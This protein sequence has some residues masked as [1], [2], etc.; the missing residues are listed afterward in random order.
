MQRR[1]IRTEDIISGSCAFSQPFPP[2]FPPPAPGTATLRTCRARTP[3]DTPPSP[4]RFLAT[5][6]ISFAIVFFVVREHDVVTSASRTLFRQRLDASHT[7]THTCALTT[8]SS[9]RGRSGTV[10]KRNRGHRVGYERNDDWWG[11]VRVSSDGHTVSDERGGPK[12]L[13]YIFSVVVHWKT[14]RLIE[15][16]FT[17]W[18]REKAAD[19]FDMILSELEYDSF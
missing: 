16:R 13:E 15:N 10:L 2:P 12:R 9:G 18:P 19:E 17:Q 6:T 7:H 14:T 3:N 8:C 5:I 1:Y 11:R 4:V